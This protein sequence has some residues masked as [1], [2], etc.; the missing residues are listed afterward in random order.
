MTDVPQHTSQAPDP[1]N[2]EMIDFRNSAGVHQWSPSLEKNPLLDGNP[3]QTLKTSDS[4]MEAIEVKY[5][6]RLKWPLAVIFGQSLL[7]ALSWGFVAATR[8]R[9][10]ITLNI[11][12]AEALQRYPRGTTYVFTLVATGLSTFSSYLLSQAVRHAVVMYLKR[13]VALSSFD[14]ALSISKQSL[15]FDQEFQALPWVFTAAVFYFATIQQTSSWSTLLPPISIQVATPLEGKELDMTTDAF[16]S[17]FNDLWLNT[18]TLYSFVDSALLSIIDASGSTRANWAAGYPGALAFEGYAYWNSTGGTIPIQLYPAANIA[19]GHLPTLP[20]KPLPSFYTSFNASMHQQGLTTSVSCQL[21]NL[22][23]NSD[24]PLT[25]VIEP[26]NL[27]LSN[28]PYTIVE[29]GSTCNGQPISY[30]VI[31][32]GNDTLTINTLSA[33]V[34]PS[35]YL[36]DTTTYRIIIAGRGGYDPVNIGAGEGS[37]VCEITP[38]IQNVV[39]SYSIFEIAYVSSTVD[40]NYPPSQGGASGMGWAAV[41]G[42]ATAIELGQGPFRNAVG[43]SI[44]SIFRDK[45]IQT[46]SYPALWEQYIQGV[47]EFVGTALKWELTFPTGPLGGDPPDTMLRKINGTILTATFGWQYDATANL[48]LLLPITFVA[49]ASI[50]IVLVPTV[51]YRGCMVAARHKDFDPGNPMFLLAAASA[52]GLGNT[53]ADLTKENVEAGRKT[54]VTLGQIDDRDGFKSCPVE[55]PSEGITVKR[56]W[57]SWRKK[58]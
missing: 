3:E 23:A 39:T 35:T 10:Q 8:A 11:V 1:S 45:R 50:V 51:Q 13:P 49:F 56:S 26:A 20:T 4:T 42:L 34:C 15:I 7:L 58:A 33:L 22:N 30:P 16:H 29:A 24:P 27:T 53:F 6:R 5:T 36:P 40:P 44:V 43:N 48:L 57:F 54:K 2:M 37:V 31:S 18:T 17:R 21:Q 41:Y 25:S 46:I 14:F 47:I 12:V 38:V 55:T 28:Q 32:G 9:G 19:Q 52:G